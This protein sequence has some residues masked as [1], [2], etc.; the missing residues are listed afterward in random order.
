M[1][2]RVLDGAFVDGQLLAK[3]DVLQGELRS[4]LRHELQHLELSGNELPGKRVDLGS[5]GGHN[6][7]GG[8]GLPSFA[9]ARGA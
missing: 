3:S 7:P 8:R 9:P 1:F 4:A 6:V 2:V 5:G